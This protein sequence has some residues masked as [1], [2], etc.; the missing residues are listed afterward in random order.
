MEK[1]IKNLEDKQSEIYVDIEEMEWGQDYADGFVEGWLQAFEMAI[2]IVKENSDL[3]R[4]KEC[5]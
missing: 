1:L 3:F 2:L 4:V 5:E